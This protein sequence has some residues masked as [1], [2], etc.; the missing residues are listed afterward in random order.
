MLYGDNATIDAWV[1]AI[2]SEEDF[3][4]TYAK[5]HLKSEAKSKRVDTTFGIHSARAW[6]GANIFRYRS[7]LP[8]KP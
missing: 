7:L 6:I 3:P 4:E 1:N 8:P 5:N 2:F